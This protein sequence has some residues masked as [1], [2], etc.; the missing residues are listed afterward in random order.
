MIIVGDIMTTNI[1]TIHHDAYISDLAD[2]FVANNISGTPIVD[3]SDTVVGFVSKSD[4]VRFDSMGGDPTYVRLN[5]IATHRVVTIRST[6]KIKIAAETMLHENIHHL[7]VKDN[8]NLV[9]VISSF[10]FV[11]L[12]ASA[13]GATLSAQ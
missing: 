5:E 13:N 11:K 1:Q 9:G 8:H 10:D 12:A 7:V 6:E 4:V 2:F 3:D